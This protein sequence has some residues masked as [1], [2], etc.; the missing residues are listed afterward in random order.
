MIEGLLGRKIG[1]T[2]VFDQTG[3]VIPVTIIEVGPCVVTQIRTKERDGYEAVQIGYQEVRAKSL[4]KPEQ[5]HLRGAGKL[6]RHLREFRADNVAD[7]K[8]G[9]VLT[10]EMFEP[11]QRIDVIGTSKGRGFQGVVKRHASAAGHERTVRATVCGRPVRSAPAPIQ[12][13][14]GRIRGWPGG[15]AING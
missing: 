5:G 12:V 3:Q 8:V 10:V 9:D 14:C 7:H 1:M 4:T 11:G 6:V 13:I 15:W 2:Q